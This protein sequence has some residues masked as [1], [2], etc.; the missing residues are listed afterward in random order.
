MDYER[1]SRMSKTTIEVGDLKVRVVTPDELKDEISN[2]EHE[3][4]KRATAAV[5][6]AIHKAKVCN[7]PVAKYDSRKKKAYIEQA[8]GVKEYVK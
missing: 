6:A 8:D 3:M 7:K 5:K 2:E 1:V 4:D